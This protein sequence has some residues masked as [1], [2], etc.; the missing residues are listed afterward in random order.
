M[1]L[2]LD[3]RDVV[4]RY[5]SVRALEHANFELRT[6]EVMGLLGENGAGKSTLVKVLAGLVLPDSGHI[7]VGGEERSLYPSYRSQ[8]AGIAVVHQE[9]CSVPSMTVAE[10][11]VLGLPT[12]PY[13]WRPKVLREH[14]RGLLD[15][16]GLHDVDPR[17]TVDS[18]SVA[19]VQ[20]LEVA[21][22]ISVDAKVV[23]FDEPTAALSD[24]EITRVMSA[25]RRL[26]ESGRSVVYITHRLAEVK[27]IC[28]R[29]TVFRNGVSLPPV[30]VDSL[31]VS[32]IVTM[33][34][35]R[36]MQTM[37]P[38]HNAI[39]EAESLLN[40]E[41][42][43]ASG[44]AEPV[45]FNVPKGNIVGLT[46]QLGSGTSAVMEALGGVRSYQAVNVQLMGSK[47]RP[48]SVHRFRRQGIAYCSP[49]R[50][51]NGIFAVRSM[52]EN[53][54]SPWL[55][56]VARLGFISRGSERG[57]VDEIAHSFAADIRRMSTPVGSLSGGNQQKVAVG[58]WLG[59][60]PRVMLLEEPTRGVDIGARAE[61][62]QSLRRVC[63]S[64]V[65]VIVASS[66]SAEIL[67]LCD[68]IGTFY[69]GRLTD[70]RPRGA[71]T[72]EELTLQVMHGE[73]Q[74]I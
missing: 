74:G 47:I 26:K 34:L 10:N 55:S 43:L 70:F 67:G 65:G 37:F 24:K 42:L 69:R 45:S 33:M 38:D 21:R 25:I 7:S 19:E 52:R 30:A 28:D 20:L 2:S 39:A 68:W 56:R 58:R 41:G 18:L 6:G 29:V 44:L 57:Q 54:S 35:G 64:G 59:I 36:E 1:D 5:G 63:D 27:E 9:Y 3:V 17:A 51:R 32:D 11:L 15:A 61:I 14:A 71:W 4:K 53:L 50:K 73:R 8:D 22:V 23:I 31:E 72:A 48:G 66:D 12:S 62:Y 46:G 16:V 40:V 60:A 49:D 13:M